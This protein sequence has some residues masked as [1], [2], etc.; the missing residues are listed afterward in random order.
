M[1][2]KKRWGAK[3]DQQSSGADN[4]QPQQQLKL[5]SDTS[6]ATTTKNGNVAAAHIQDSVAEGIKNDRRNQALALSSPDRFSVG[7][8]SA[9]DLASFLA[10]INDEH[11]FCIPEF[12]C[13]WKD[14][15]LFDQLSAELDFT[16]VWLAGGTKLLRP[17]C[18]GGPEIWAKSAAY[19]SIVRKLVTRFRISDPIRSIVNLYRS[20][21]DS[22]AYHRDAYYRD[23]NFTV[24]VSFG[25]TRE[26]HFA[27]DEQYNAAVGGGSGAAGSS[28]K[29]FAFPQAN[30][31]LFA[32]S[33]FVNSRFRHAVPKEKK[34]CGPRI[35]LV[36]WG[37]RRGGG[38]PGDPRRGGAGDT[39]IPP[40]G[41]GGD[42]HP[43]AK[44][45]GW[46]YEEAW[47]RDP[48]GFEVRIEESPQLSYEEPPVRDEVDY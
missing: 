28:N 36:L 29:S 13:R 43:P 22:T 46:T 26:I 20:E 24:G 40:R 3:K 34:P 23:T 5:L 44:G 18:I 48:E 9:N 31:D 39:S 21:K 25:A 30:G 15:S 41:G 1:A 7:P 4:E 47:R 6:A 42:V 12:G 8:S 11:T 19:R 35:S 27:S 33:N 32:F 45:G 37:M 10:I 2:P 38:E 17:A 14:F 16:S